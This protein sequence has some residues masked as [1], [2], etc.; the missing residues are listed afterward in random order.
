MKVPLS[1]SDLEAQLT[2][3]LYF[4][5]SSSAS[6]DDGFE[7]EAFRMAT[8]LRVLVHDTPNSSSLLGQLGKKGIK[9]SDTAIPFDEDNLLAH[10][11]L[12]FTH[13]GDHGARY[14]ARLDDVPSTFQRD[15]DEWWTAP[16]FKD[17][18]GRVLTRK[19]VVLIAANQDGGAHVDPKLDETYFELTR[20]NSLG[21]VASDG[22]NV[23]P[24]DGPERAALRQIAHEMMKT[25]RPDFKQ[26]PVHASGVMVG[27][28][29]FKKVDE[30]ATTTAQISG[31]AVPKVGRNEPCPCGSGIKYKKCHGRLA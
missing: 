26:M 7:D 11:G 9:F 25:L 4:L 10:S 13:F 19:D 20:A 27:G 3:Q 15:F 17:G 5:E 1:Q 16:V 31:G 24:F 14:V 6:F 18:K 21:W 2:R 12:V 30:K 8:T 23:T 29:S 28:F 22:I